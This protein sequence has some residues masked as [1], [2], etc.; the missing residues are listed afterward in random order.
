[1]RLIFLVT[2][3]FGI[4]SAAPQERLA[5]PNIFG[6]VYYG[7]QFNDCSG[8]Y[9]RQ[10]R[11]AD[12]SIFG[13]DFFK[14]A[15]S[16]CTG[17]NCYP[18]SKVET[19]Q[20]VPP[21][22]NVG[23][24]PCPYYAGHPYQY[25]CNYAPYT[26]TPNPDKGNAVQVDPPTKNV[27]LKSSKIFGGPVYGGVYS[28][29][30]PSHPVP[31]WKR[32]VPFW[33]KPVPGVP[34]W[35]NPWSNFLKNFGLSLYGNGGPVHIQGPVNNDDITIDTYNG[36]TFTDCPEGGCKQKLPWNN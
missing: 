28:V 4:T 24:K 36:G 21:T 19:D 7:G 26:N 13:G 3:T 8:G 11:L 23:L 33:K 20:S 16:A 14:N 32:P 6:N 2:I 35:R 17:G 22:K 10:G 31:F 18:G 25:L 15:I 30:V 1:M 5:D 12:P 9:C 29:N 27:G 34:F